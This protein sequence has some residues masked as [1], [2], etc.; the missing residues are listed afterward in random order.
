MQDNI[1]ASM[2]GSTSPKPIQQSDIEQDY[3]FLLAQKVSEQM[4]KRLVSSI[5]TPLSTMLLRELFA[6]TAVISGP[7]RTMTV[8]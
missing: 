4:M 8:T 2:P 3:D 6:Q 1:T 7:A 5:S